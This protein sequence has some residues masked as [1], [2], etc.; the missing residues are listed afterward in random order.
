[1]TAQRPFPSETAVKK[2]FNEEHIIG[3]ERKPRLERSRSFR[4]IFTIQWRLPRIE[5][6]LRKIAA[7]PGILRLLIRALPILTSDRF[8]P[9]PPQSCA[10]LRQK[11]AQHHAP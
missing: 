2:R 5:N 11:P 8:T 1:M 3:N 10:M 7:P 4:S 6:P 9:M